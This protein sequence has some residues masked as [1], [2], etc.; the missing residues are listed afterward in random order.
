MEM[1]D[2]RRIRRRELL[3]S[4]G[5]FFAALTLAA[6]AR[7]TP[8]APSS[9][10]APA[11][12]TAPLATTKPAAA[13]GRSQLVVAQT[14]DMVTLDP[15]MYRARQTQNIHQMLYDTLVHRTDDL[16]D[17]GR[18]AESWEV[19]DE[20]TF[21]FKMRAN[22]RFH[23]GSPVTARDVKFSYD[24]TLD[25]ALK[26][27][28]AGLLD[29]VA[30]TDAPDDATVIV[31]TKTPDPL[32][33]T[34]LN[35]HAI[36]PM[37][38]VSANLDAFL[39]KP[40]GA[41]PFMF[42]EWK[43][44]ER[45]VL[46]A[47]PNYWDGAPLVQTL[48]F[49]PIPDPSAMVAELESGGIDIAAEVPP[50]AFA[51]LKANPN[52]QALTAPSTTVHYVGLNTRKPPLDNVN[53]RQALNMAIDKTAIINSVLVG[54]AVPVNG[55]LFPESRGYD[56]SLKGYA[57]DVSAAKAMLKDAGAEAEFSMQL[58]TTAATKEAAEAVAGQLKQ[59]GVTANVNVM[60]LGVLTTKI[61]SGECD[62][63]F[64]TWG[65]SAA[66]G[67][68]TF[69]RHFHSSQRQTFKDTWYSKPE[70]DKLI[71][72]ARFTFDFEKRRQLLMQALKSIVDDAPWLFLWQP[73]TLAA[74]R[75]SVKGFTPRADGYMFLNKAAPA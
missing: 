47:N 6:C 16:K 28:R 66:D 34:F 40:I 75:A 15:P 54:L 3:G 27:P 55:P 14:A 7:S 59:V 43:K 42:Q 51:G 23:D 41:G 44:D 35:Y 12:T 11:A 31:K 52:L 74:A 10:T 65:D 17:Q 20:T 53:V 9:T 33:L 67:G 29:N 13:S 58:D 36:T 72:D 57:F 61:N 24:R 22:A 25:P 1:D 5:G 49:R 30:S 50:A 62:M 38:A 19:V 60:E 69:Y 68:V 73:N 56:P 64:N 21:K 45:V 63:Y 48:I 18:L 71:D 32:T 4:S 8:T 37:A 70:L 46:S 2:A 26:A 39:Q